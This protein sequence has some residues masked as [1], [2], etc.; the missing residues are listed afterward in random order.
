MKISELIDK[1]RE[2]QDREGDLRVIVDDTGLGE[3]EPDP[4]VR[5]NFKGER[6][7]EI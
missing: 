4:I 3:W 1:L 2:I 7:V 6:N 5:E